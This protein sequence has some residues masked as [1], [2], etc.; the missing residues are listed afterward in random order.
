VGTM[1]PPMICSTMEAPPSVKSREWCVGGPGTVNA[2]GIYQ[3]IL[4]RHRY[5]L[6]HAY[7]DKGVDYFMDEIERAIRDDPAITLDYIRS[8]QFTMDHCGF[9][10]RPDQIARIAKLGLI[11]SCAPRYMDRSAPWLEVYGKQY[12]SWIVPVKSLLAGGVITTYEDESL[13]VERGTGLTYF[14]HVPYLLTRR[15]GAGELIAPEEAV[16]RVTVMKM[17]TSWASVHVGRPD[18]LGTLELGKWA[19]FVIL[20][21]DYF[22]EPVEEIK[23]IYPLL[24]VVGGKMVVLRAELAQEL[25]VQPVG[26]QIN[27]T[28]ALLPERQ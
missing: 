4:M 24:T 12:G 2:E 9:W 10:P 7:A 13:S 26:P 17:M 18:V 20:N 23:K 11:V 5:A 1:A 15:N 19:D 22:S 25:G 3:S 21:K 14:H 6:G 27:F 16:D 28:S 8:R